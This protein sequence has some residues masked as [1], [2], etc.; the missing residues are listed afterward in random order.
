MKRSIPIGMIGITIFI[1]S[2][3]SAPSTAPKEPPVPTTQPTA[4]PATE[5][6][7]DLSPE[8][9]P[10][11][12]SERGPY[13]V[14]TS[15]L[16]L[17][18]ANRED[19]LVMI[20]VWYPAVQP[21]DGADNSPTR[22]AAPDVI[23]APYPL[24][25]SSS[26]VAKLFA[27]YL[28]SQGFVWASVDGID[29]YDHMNK[30]M[31]TQPLDILFTLDQ[32]ASSPPE[33]LEGMINSEQ[34]GVTGYS[35]DGYNTL[36]LSGARID[37]EYYLAQCPDPDPTTE[38]LVQV[39]LSAFDC[40]PSRAWDEY[41]ALVGDVITTSEDGLWQPITD[42][43]IR[44]VMPMAGEGWWLFG[45]RGLAA[46]DLPVL[47]IAGTEDELYPEN[48]LIYNHLGT[49]EKNMI[50]FIGDGHMVM[51]TDYEHIAQIAHFATAFFGYHLQGHEEYADFFSKDF[52]DQYDDLF[53]GE[54]KK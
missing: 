38:P 11:S 26:K 40:G 19:R 5:T 54:Y 32:V 15:H 33:G 47:I 39:D 28:V 20:T 8:L 16:S 34:V 46:V 21:T 17:H 7:Q 4:P 50:S 22:D 52:V 30:Q 31:V 23:S 43:R 24:I 29:A 13:H 49:S 6:A 42:D 35:F 27:P 12:F 36:A 41:A 37:P 44:A 9:V 10:Y 18:D 53:W 3:C 45:E 2:A 48:V 51:V 1:L 14:G 25:L